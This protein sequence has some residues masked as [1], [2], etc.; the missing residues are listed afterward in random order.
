MLGRLA[1]IARREH[2]YSTAVQ[3]ASVVLKYD[4][5]REDAHQTLMCCYHLQLSRDAPC[6][7]RIHRGCTAAPRHIPI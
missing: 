2:D 6:W 5:G 1:D 7:P 4:G 3:F